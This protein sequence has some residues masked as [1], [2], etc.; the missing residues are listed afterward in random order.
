MLIK[1]WRPISL[2]NMDAK[3]ISKV[4]ATRLKKVI[5]F[6][7]TSNQTAYIPGR[8]IGESVHLISDTD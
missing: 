7:V 6:L 3:I 2:L 8:F 1:N 5:S 4:L